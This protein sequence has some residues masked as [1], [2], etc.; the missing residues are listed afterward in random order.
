[1]T[2]WNTIDQQID[3]IVQKLHNFKARKCPDLKATLVE[4]IESLS[5]SAPKERSIRTRLVVLLREDNV[6]DLNYKNELKTFD[7]PTAVEEAIQKSNS[8]RTGAKIEYCNLVLMQMRRSDKPSDPLPKTVDRIAQHVVTNSHVVPA[9]KYVLGMAD[10]ARA[11]FHL[12]L[13]KV[14]AI[15][16]RE[17]AES[18]RRAQDVSLLVEQTE[19]NLE[20]EPQAAEF[21]PGTGGAGTELSLQWKSYSH[22][23]HRQ[24]L[25]GALASHKISPLHPGEPCLE[26][27]LSHICDGAPVLLMP[28]YLK[29][30]LPEARRLTPSHA[31]AYH[32]GAISLFRLPSL[33]TGIPVSMDSKNIAAYRTKVPTHSRLG[34]H[35]VNDSES[36]PATNSR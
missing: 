31:L 26:A 17:S 13:L 16:V 1:M 25:L 11:N 6:K 33:P 24:H 12:K 3:T 30:E 9:D 32:N 8:L 18:L 36:S 23:K 34:I 5:S 4:A 27:L 10:L 14:C 28:G 20:G 35:R 19:G 21:L 22:R 29:P 15:P 7:I 2:G